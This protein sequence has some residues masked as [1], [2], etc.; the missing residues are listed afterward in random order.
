[1]LGLAG[2]LR[3]HPR[4]G[5]PVDT[6]ARGATLPREQQAASLQT[7]MAGWRTAPALFAA[8]LTLLAALIAATGFLVWREQDANRWVRHTIE[9]EAQLARVQSLLQEAESAQR[10]YL[11]VGN[12][13]FLAPYLEARAG[14]DRE[15]AELGQVVADNPQQKQAVAELRKVADQRLATLQTGIE[16]RR[17]AGLPAAVAA[18]ER[19]N[20][21]AMMRQT[22]QL[23]SAMNSNEEQLLAQRQMELARVEHW[24]QGAVAALV[25][26][27]LLLSAAAVGRARRQALAIAEGNQELRQA[28][29][30]LVQEA[31]LREQLEDQL[32]QAQ[33]MEAIGQ[34]T[35]GLAHDFNNMLAVIV[36][37]LQLLSRRVAQG[38]TD[39]GRLLE[40]ALDG[41]NRAATLTGRLLAFA[42][43]QP[44]NPTPLDA[45]KFVAG[46][47]DLLRRSLGEEI[48]L[49]T[50]LAG[51]LWRTH[52]DPSQ[53][54]GAL[55]NLA[56]N[57]RDA[58]P[59]GG[60]LTIETGN[61]YLDEAYAARQID[62]PP[63]QYR[64]AR[65]VRYR[66]RHAAGGYRPRLR[67]ILHHQGCRQGN[68]AGAEPGVWVRPAIRRACE[69][70][71]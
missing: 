33:K 22:Q 50:I 48:R 55:L 9:V 37:N 52:A 61:A 41:A 62:V 65:G 13:G 34:L 57:A 51:G 46:M 71:Q 67:S 24:L 11:L 5:S 19:G 36:G 30:R 54:E 27:M 23:I 45:N 69:N 26:L 21:R 40:S 43:R 4:S 14:F 44:L 10:G 59:D 17:I 64:H 47:S 3:R 56:V 66:R 63:G 68:R 20:G 49:E 39:V 53:L 70:L 18:V 42:R 25:L 60:R 28:H 31:L 58:M 6:D 12:D 7:P 38:R 2:R 32:R 15:I 1:M 16:S 29:D 8:G 35:G